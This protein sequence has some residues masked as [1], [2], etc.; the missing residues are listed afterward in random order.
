MASSSNC[1]HGQPL[2]HYPAREVPD[3]A[4]CQ[5]QST[6]RCPVVLLE[7]SGIHRFCANRSGGCDP[8][9]H[10]LYPSLVQSL[11]LP[12]PDA[13]DQAARAL[14]RGDPHAANLS[15]ILRAHLQLRQLLAELAD[16]AY[17]TEQRLPAQVSATTRRNLN[18]AISRAQAALEES[19]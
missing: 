7:E 10:H 17:E 13:I 2:L 9:Q 12:E 8:G 14:G 11:A 6:A 3:C 5:A 15:V 4:L 1:I 19:L 16:A 18:A